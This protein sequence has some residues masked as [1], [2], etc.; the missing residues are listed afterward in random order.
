MRASIAVVA[1]VSVK[2]TV[3]FYNLTKN[4]STKS[5]ALSFPETEA[6]T[7]IDALINPTAIKC[8]GILDAPSCFEITD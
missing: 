4:L 5:T 6:T 8:S 1:S 2:Q 3:V 7:A